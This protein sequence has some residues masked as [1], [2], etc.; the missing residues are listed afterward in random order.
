M[1]QNIPNPVPELHASGQREVAGAHQA[2]RRAKSREVQ[3]RQPE[4]LVPPGQLA[5]VMQFANAVDAGRVD[6]EQI[7]AA[8]AQSGQP[9]NIEEIQ[10]SPLS[11]TQL[12]DAS[13]SPTSPGGF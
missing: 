4:V 13:G 10:I 7:A 8:Q 2:L 11:I 3:E 5:A 9:L 1:A 12:D 6:G